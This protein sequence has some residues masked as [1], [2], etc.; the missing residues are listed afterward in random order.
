MALLTSASHAMGL[1]GVMKIG[2]AGQNV[3]LII[4][5]M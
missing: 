2:Q 1:T 4:K 3:T 5:I